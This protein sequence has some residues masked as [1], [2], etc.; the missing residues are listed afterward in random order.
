M[1]KRR[2]SIAVADGITVK[3]GGA[4]GHLG[5]RKAMLYKTLLKSPLS[6]RKEIFR[7]LHSLTKS[8]LWIRSQSVPSIKLLSVPNPKQTSPGRQTAMRLVTAALA[9]LAATPIGLVL[10]DGAA[11]GAAIQQIS[12][13]TSDLQTTVAGFNGNPL[14]IPRILLQSS[15]LLVD[16]NKATA[17]AQSSANLT[18]AGASPSSPFLSRRSCPLGCPSHQLG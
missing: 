4:I 15:V 12:S 7:P 9:L 17:V 18:D 10:G 1:E 5:R 2:G 8:S 3:P 16:I 11:I 13:D 14:T 6:E